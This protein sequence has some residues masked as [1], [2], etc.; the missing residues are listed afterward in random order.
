M[1]KESHGRQDAPYTDAKTSPHLASMLE[2]YGYSNLEEVSQCKVALF[3]F[4]KTANQQGV[5][6]DSF[7][8]QQ[9]KSGLNLKILKGVAHNNSP[10]GAITN[11][12]VNTNTW[13]HYFHAGG[14]NTQTLLEIDLGG[15]YYIK[16]IVLTSKWDHNLHERQNGTHVET[17]NSNKERINLVQ[18]GCSWNNLTKHIEF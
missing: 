18:L 16:N 1:K 2:R 8:K 3:E 12:I 10:P 5:N 15:E 4:L 6:T 11:G 17:L 13:N 14:T 9:V 7:I